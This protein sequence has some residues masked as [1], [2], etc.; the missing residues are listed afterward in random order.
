M[1]NTE[2][3]R[4][5]HV[6]GLRLAVCVAAGLNFFGIFVSIL[7]NGGWT[8]DLASKLFTSFI[9]IGTA[10]YVLVAIFLNNK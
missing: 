4:K 10:L 7:T 2:I 6:G 9:I 1:D 3:E 8:S 5:R